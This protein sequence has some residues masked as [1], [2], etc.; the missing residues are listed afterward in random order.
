[1]KLVPATLKDSDF[2]LDLKNDRAVRKASFDQNKTSKTVH[3][4]WFNKALRGHRQFIY[5]LKETGMSVASG[6]LTIDGVFAEIHLAVPP[7]FRGCGYGPWLIKALIRRA[8]SKG[9]IP[10]AQVKLE[11][12][13]SIK[14]FLRA[15]MR[16][17][18]PITFVTPK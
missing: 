12:L 2:L 13:A 9:F 15:G 14:A 4:A 18:K 17:S 8:R 3:E 6:R 1:M 5:I 7:I 16:P 11:N 10:I